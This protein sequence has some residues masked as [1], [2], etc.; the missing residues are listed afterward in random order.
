MV[1]YDAADIWN[2]IDLE[3][4]TWRERANQKT[5]A[6]IARGYYDKEIDKEG[7]GEIKEVFMR[8]QA[9]KCAYCERK[10]AGGLYGKREH[11]VEHFRPKGRLSAW[12]SKVHKHL[13]S[14]IPPALKQYP[15]PLGAAHEKGYHKLAFH[16]LNYCTACARCNQSL[17]LDFFP[18]RGERLLDQADPQ[19]LKTEKP[20]LIYPVGNLD[21]DPRA[22]LTFEGV[23]PKPISKRGF[24][25]ERAIVTIDFFDLGSEDLAIERADILKLMYFPLC[26]INEGAAHPQYADAEEIVT[27]ST[28]ARAPHSS[29]ALAYQQ[30]FERDPVLAK[31]YFDIAKAIVTKAQTNAA[32]GN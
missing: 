12:P 13:F 32:Q 11:D 23:S 18:V 17:K 6:I 5:Q 24:A 7:W 2:R 26:I 25:R 22:L 29:C 16:P 8:L 27:L 9:N 31:N 28:S 14:G 1:R 30:T 20:F 19:K 3:N 10:L 15:H 21:T 4:S